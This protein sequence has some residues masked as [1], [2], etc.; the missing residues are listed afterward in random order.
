MQAHIIV[1]HALPCGVLA[2]RPPVAVAYPVLPVITAD[3]VT[4]R[5]AVDRSVK[6]LQQGHYIRP[7][8]FNIVRRHE[9]RCAYPYLSV[10]FRLNGK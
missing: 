6:L 1:L 4:P 7:E 2:R 10:P 9:A 3:E 5:P 8:S